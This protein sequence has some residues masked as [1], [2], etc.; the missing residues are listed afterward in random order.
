MNLKHV[1]SRRFRVVAHFDC[2]P[3]QTFLRGEGSGRTARSSEP[4]RQILVSRDHI[5]A[6]TRVRRGIFCR[7]ASRMRSFK[8]GEEALARLRKSYA[9][10][11]SLANRLLFP[12]MIYS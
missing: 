4:I 3:E 10:C 12:W 6:A 2:H 7:P 11:E 9:F 8:V 5:R 1:N